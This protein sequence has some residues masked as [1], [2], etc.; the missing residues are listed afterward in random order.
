MGLLGGVLERKQAGS[1]EN[2]E[3]THLRDGQ[4]WPL[5]SQSDS[6]WCKQGCMRKG[7]YASSLW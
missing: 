1:E 3:S 7:I 2:L 4:S 5:E 6:A